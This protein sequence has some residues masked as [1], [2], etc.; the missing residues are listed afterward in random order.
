MSDTALKVGLGVAA[1][2]GIGVGVYALTRNRGSS[3]RVITQQPATGRP[4]DASENPPGLAPGTGTSQAMEEA[5]RK[6]AAEKAE[7]DRLAAIQAELERQ[8]AEEAARAKQ[9]EISRLRSAAAGIENDQVLVLTRIRAVYDDNSRL[10]DFTQQY[11]NEQLSSGRFESLV[12][13]CKK[14]VWNNCPGN[15][16]MKQI[17]RCDDDNYPMCEKRQSELNGYA[18]GDWNGNTD[19]NPWMVISE[20]ASN[21]S[22]TNS[23]PQRLARWKLE[24]VR[25]LEAEL[26]RLEVQY[27]GV[28]RELRERFGVEFQSQKPE[29]HSYQPMA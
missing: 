20:E 2:A 4:I 8:R 10:Q 7:Q 6:A 23:G 9:A 19:K 18:R 17:G 5:A 13:S 27:V 15:D 11:I 3:P 1:L 21:P 26:A 14:S 16:W 24:Q 12:N 22:V 29:A 25:P 28:V